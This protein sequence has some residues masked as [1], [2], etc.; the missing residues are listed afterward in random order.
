MIYTKSMIKNYIPVLS[1]LEHFFKK[2]SIYA[3][4]SVF[5][6]QIYLKINDPMIISIAMQDIIGIIGKIRRNQ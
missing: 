5:F 1:L 6:N 2:V 3:V 4:C